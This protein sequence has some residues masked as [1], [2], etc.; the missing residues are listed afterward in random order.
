[1]EITK[2]K[3][4]KNIYFICS[5]TQK[6]KTAM[7]GALSS[8]GDLMGGIFDRWINT[9]PE[10]IIFNEYI[11]PKLNQYNNSNIEL[12]QDFY[13][14][15]PKEVGI[16]PDVL[17]IKINNKEIPFCIYGK[18]GNEIRW[19]QNK[20]YPQIEVKTL[21]TS[22]KMLTLRDQHYSGKYLIFAESTFNIDYLLPFFDENLFNQKV[23]D[24][25]KMN[26]E[27]F[28]EENYSNYITQI[29]KINLGNDRIGDVN[30]LVITKAEDFINKSIMCMPGESVQYINNN[31]SERNFVKKPKTIIDIPLSNYLI[32]K[33]NSVYRFNENWY[34]DFVKRQNIKTL[35][36]KI[37]GLENVKIIKMN[38]DS[39]YI[40]VAGEAIINNFKLNNDIYKIDF[41]ILERSASSPKEYFLQ[42]HIFDILENSEMSL[43]TE[44]NTIIKDN[45]NG[46]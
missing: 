18:I 4:I 8:K 35:D 34:N 21:K 41:A 26:N 22:Q 14:Y 25:L 11:K 29:N 20:N 45:I 31:I 13:L 1:M 28:L 32:K 17:G 24:E 42:K 23:F 33:F 9:I 5:L 39:I 44:L 15:D 46:N 6:T 19:H 27:T 12:I 40:K 37:D 16:A 10:S 43:I 38:K 36:I 2:D 30:V 3:S 7:Q